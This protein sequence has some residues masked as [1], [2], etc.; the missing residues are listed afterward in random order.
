M[1]KR[2]KKV[3]S[4]IV[5]CILLVVMIYSLV[6]LMNQCTHSKINSKINSNN[7]KTVTP[8][9]AGRLFIIKR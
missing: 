6:M 3:L 9:P 1:K 8:L 2:R 7:W 5:R 4:L